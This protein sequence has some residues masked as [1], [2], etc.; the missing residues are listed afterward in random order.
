MGY[1]DRMQESRPFEVGKWGEGGLDETQG[2]G[3]GHNFL[4]H[5]RCEIVNWTPP[6]FVTDYVPSKHEP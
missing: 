6:S 4:G 2:L 5:S 3:I 1:F